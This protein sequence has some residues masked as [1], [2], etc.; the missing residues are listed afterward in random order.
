MVTQVSLEVIQ[1]LSE[2][3][4]GS[5]HQLELVEEDIN[6]VRLAGERALN[7]CKRKVSELEE[8]VQKMKNAIDILGSTRRYR[9]CDTDWQGGYI[10][11]TWP[12]TVRCSECRSR[13]YMEA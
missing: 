10:E 1:E 2:R 12:H 11:M 6:E 8:E 7:S 4:R 3:L 13:Q 5:K 9:H